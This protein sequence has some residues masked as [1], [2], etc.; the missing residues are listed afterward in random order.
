MGLNRRGEGMLEC[1]MTVYPAQQHLIDWP[2]VALVVELLHQLQQ[3]VPSLLL[4]YA[5]ADIRYH[6]V[7]PSYPAVQA[8]VQETHAKVEIF[9]RARL[10]RRGPEICLDEPETEQRVYSLVADVSKP[11]A[12]RAELVHPDLQRGNGFLRRARKREHGSVI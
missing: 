4:P 11:Y 12:V 5:V 7:G 8:F 2:R 3:A 9:R 6:L 10:R 1:W